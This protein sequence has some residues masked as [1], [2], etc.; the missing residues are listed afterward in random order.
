[1]YSAHG[2]LI[3]RLDAVPLQVWLAVLAVLALRG[4]VARL[5]MWPYAVFALPGTLAHELAHWLVAKLLFARP[6]FPDLVPSR[7]AHGWRLG[8]VTFSAPW[9]RAAPIA[10]APVVLMPVALLWIVGPASGAAGGWLAVHAW[11]AGTLLGASL[12][13]RAD[14]RLAMPAI[15]LILACTA[16]WLAIRLP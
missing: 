15:A 3:D 2:W 10:V 5:G 6:R 14:W 1:M 7:T 16:A 8:S 12:P 4:L 9:W 13:S 11:I